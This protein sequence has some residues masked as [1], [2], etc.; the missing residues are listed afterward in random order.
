MNDQKDKLLE[1]ANTYLQLGKLL[2]KKRNSWA[3]RE[4]EK[5]I[6]LNISYEEKIIR[7]IK[8]DEAVLRQKEILHK[9]KPTQQK[10]HKSLKHEIDLPPE[11]LQKENFVIY[12]LFH[13]TKIARFGRKTQTLKT[14]FINLSFQ[15]HPKVG[16]SL[17][18]IHKL[19][20]ELID[21]LNYLV[22]KGWMILTKEEYNIIFNFYDFCDQYY[23][24]FLIDFDY[25]DLI[26]MQKTFLM[27]TKD[28]SRIELLLK[29]VEKGLKD[30]SLYSLRVKTLIDKIKMIVYPNI[31]IPSLTN[32][33]LAIQ[34]MD[35]KRFCRFSDLVFTENPPSIKKNI[36]LAPENI[37]GNIKRFIWEKQNLL[38]DKEKEY[39]YLLFIIEKFVPNWENHSFDLLKKFSSTNT[40]TT[41]QPLQSVSDLSKF[42]LL[43]LKEYLRVFKEFTLEKVSLITTDNHVVM[44]KIIPYSLDSEFRSIQSEYHFLSDFMKEHPLKNIAYNRY[45]EY[46]NNGITVSD[47]ENAL[48]TIIK[49]LSNSFYQISIKLFQN[50][51]FE[52]KLDEIPINKRL[53]LFQ[54]KDIF[55]KTIPYAKGRL[56]LN[57]YL[58]NKT[59]LEA[60][61]SL[62]EF[63]VN[64]SLLFLNEDLHRKLKAIPLMREELTKLIYLI[65]RME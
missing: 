37:M 21:P 45:S 18:D 62:M 60:Y 10:P 11:K 53:E 17:Y 41:N 12:L 13:F 34:M 27:I 8:I 15:M 7:I 42:L 47:D 30:H 56:N 28:E 59:V 29:S 61:L 20:Q 1:S 14:K 36:Y 9:K 25:T 55:E 22:E 24:D 32:I 65:Q 52:N 33:L 48:F 19:I 39:H 57:Y 50:Y 2:K 4:V 38:D 16:A 49:K 51:A 3:N 23:K 40:E 31:M 5:I 63:S 43:L 58:S 54:D 6:S 35:L 44:E 64:F 46:V 26:L